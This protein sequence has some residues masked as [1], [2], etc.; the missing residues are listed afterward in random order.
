MRN[1]PGWIFFVSDFYSF[2]FLKKANTSTMKYFYLTANLGGIL[3]LTLGISAIAIYEIIYF[4]IYK[5]IAV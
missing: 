2:K 5:L 1:I 3:N 4:F